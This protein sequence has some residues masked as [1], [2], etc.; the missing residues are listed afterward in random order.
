MSQLNVRTVHS[1]KSITITTSEEVLSLVLTRKLFQVCPPLPTLHGNTDRCFEDDFTTSC[2]PTGIQYIPKYQ[3]STTSTTGTATSTSTTPSATSTCTPY[4][5]KGYLQAYGD[6]Q[7]G[8]LIS[9]GTWYSATG[10]SCATY[11][12]VF[13]DAT[14]SSFTL[15]SSKGPCGIVADKLS[16]SANMTYTDFTSVNG[17]LANAAG[18]NQFYA[19]GI[20]TGSVQEPVYD[21]VNTTA[22]QFQWQAISC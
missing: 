22:V 12:G 17:L 18:D 5:G 3:N 1:M 13:T 7:T 15:K 4:N 21:T 9:Y 20:P 10:T 8:C 14:N 6:S 16:C 2:P 11:T 19:P